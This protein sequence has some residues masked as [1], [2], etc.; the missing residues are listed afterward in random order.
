MRLTGTSL[1]GA[2]QGE[3]AATPFRAFNPTLGQELEPAYFPATASEVDRAAMLAEAASAEY[4]C[5]SGQRRG[6]LLGRIAE[7]LEASAA[8]IVARAH[9]E[10][11]L[12]AARLEGELARTCFQLR[13]YGATA[14]QGSWVDARID[15]A[16]PQR[17]PQPKPD[18]RSMLRPIGPVAVFGASNFP[19]AYSVAGGDTASALAAGC[20]V[21]VKAHPGHP[22]ASEWVGRLI[23]QAVREAGLPEGV[24]SLLFDDGY[25]V[26]VQLVRHPAV[27]AV[28]FTG[29]RQGGRALLDLA[30]GRPAPIPV[31][32]EMGSINPVFVLPGAMGQ[33]SAEIAAGYHASFTLGVGQFCTNPGVLVAPAGPPT[34]AFLTQLQALVKTTPPGTM[35]TARICATYRAGRDRFEHTPG[36]EPCATVT[37]DAPGRAGAAVFVTD[38]SNF[39]R[40]PELM[41]EIFGPSTLVVR[42]AEADQMLAVARALEGQLTASVHG[43]ETDLTTHRT[44]LALLESKAGRL[45][46][47]GFPTGVEVC[48]A[49]VHGGPYPATSA[50]SSTS[51]GTRALNRF[52][53]LICYQGFPD[54]LLPAELQEANP[55]RLGRIVDGE[56]RQP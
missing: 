17:R 34:E 39:L 25:Q 28:G 48:S 31:Y 40:H 52:T 35:L 20:P 9:L 33:R 53:R 45:V 23:Q 54:A 22:G 21:L 6:E 37:T 27:K 5:V 8:G 1:L 32:A 30:A 12:P 19:L 3:T 46:F 14:A 2:S 26:G 13:L 16:D 24:F 42:C 10:T 44:L 18:L 51:V 47:N 38:A 15:H 56:Y 41:E 49:M 4:A 29:S 50:S 55:L 11:A 36:V 43:T 7:L